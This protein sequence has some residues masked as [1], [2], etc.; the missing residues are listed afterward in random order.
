MTEPVGPYGYQP[1]P[2]P[3]PVPEQPGSAAPGRTR[4]GIGLAAVGAG[5]L[6]ILWGLVAQF[7]SLQLLRQGT[8]IHTVAWSQNV[9]GALI[10]LAALTL[11]AIGLLRKGAPHGAAGF[12]FGLGLSQLVGV[13]GSMVT[14]GILNALQ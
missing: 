12:G 10:G 1:Q 2:V 14:M 3:G 5:V 11:G 7:V 13:V 8:P 6:L 9:V 4:N